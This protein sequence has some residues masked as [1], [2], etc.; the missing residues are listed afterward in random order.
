MGV[1]VVPPLVKARRYF[2]QILY[3]QPVIFDSIFSGVIKKR[4]K[5]LYRHKKITCFFICAIAGACLLF[6][7]HNFHPYITQ[8]DN[9]RDL[10][11][12]QQTFHGKMPYRDYFWQYGPLMPYYYSCIFH[13][14]GISIKS[15]VIGR[16]LTI[17]LDGLLVYLTLSIFI[18]PFLAM[19][20]A[21]WFWAFHPNFTFTFNHPGG[22]TVIFCVVYCLF[23]YIENL[24]QRWVRAGYFLS[25]LLG[26]IKINF[27]FST[28][29]AF[30]LSCSAVDILKNNSKP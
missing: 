23:R 21:L 9:G 8:G 27:G 6:P 13:F 10:Y 19:T 16:L 22:V 28:L 17:F 24:R 3:I 29:T 4:F 1:V 5:K 20:A 18:R 15:A 14:L 7:Y 26:L 2:W 25:L 11:A 30:A 12:F